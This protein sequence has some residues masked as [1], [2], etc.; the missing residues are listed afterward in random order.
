M[1]ENPVVL[2]HPAT[3][4]SPAEGRGGQQGPPLDAAIRQTSRND[5][6]MVVALL[7][8][9]AGAAP[10]MPLSSAAIA[11]HPRFEDAVALLIER[12]AG[13]YG[14]DRRLVRGLFEYDRAVTF[15]LALALAVAEQ[16]DEPQSWLT[17]ARLTEGAALMG[18][19]PP[20][21]VRGFVE[22]MRID[23]HLVTTPMPGERRRHRLH[24]TEQMLAVDRQWVAAFH[25]PLMLLDPDVARY[26]AGE[27]QDPDYHRR[28][29][30]AALAT[31]EVARE[32][33]TDHPA[34]DSFLHQAGG[35]RILTSLMRSARTDAG[36]WAEPGFFTR[37]AEHSATTRA[38][39]RSMMRRAAAEGLVEISNASM[40][41][42]TPALLA[43]L[44]GWAADSLA[45][46]DLASVLT[47]TP[48]PGGR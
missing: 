46:T 22:E 38:H 15:M 45:S 34:V 25:A 35:G 26:R 11:A 37:A 5:A 44:D 14:D 20:R 2:V 1:S 19:G 30:I 32:T 12:L 6:Q 27:A 39:V 10:P 17:L 3:Y 21:R 33:I 7:E 31:L 48:G 40:V 36:G 9:H 43:D 42:A 47:L 41:R 16:D 29:R 8:K 28:Y 24:A 4:R 13:I 18:V 23:G